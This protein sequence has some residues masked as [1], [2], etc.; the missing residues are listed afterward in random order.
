VFTDRLGNKSQTSNWAIQNLAG[1]GD[2]VGQIFI[3][4]V[5][6]LQELAVYERRYSPGVCFCRGSIRTITEAVIL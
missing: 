6:Y 1:H 2:P 3:G 4:S 5:E